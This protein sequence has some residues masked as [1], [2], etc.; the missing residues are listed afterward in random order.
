M[1]FYSFKLCIGIKEHKN[2]ICM[3]KLNSIK[4]EILGHENMEPADILQIILL[5]A[6]V[7]L[8]LFIVMKLRWVI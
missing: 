6:V 8:L 2:V 1:I 4:K 5:V 3:S 7:A